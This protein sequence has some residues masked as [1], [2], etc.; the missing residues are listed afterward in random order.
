MT[1]LRGF[2]VSQ[3]LVPAVLYPDE[4]WTSEEETLQQLP[5]NFC[6]VGQN[7]QCTI[8]KVFMMTQFI[9]VILFFI[10]NHRELTFYVC[11]NNTFLFYIVH[12]AAYKL[13]C[14]YPPYTK[15]FLS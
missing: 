1:R 10:S 13:I 4:N 5:L 8:Y 7:L 14:I 11:P 9:G 3:P 12:Q 6:I 15:P 2:A